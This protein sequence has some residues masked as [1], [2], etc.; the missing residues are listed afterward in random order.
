MFL[1]YA[2]PVSEDEVYSPY[3]YYMRKDGTLIF[4]TGVLREGKQI[5]IL[6]EPVRF[7][8]IVE[9]ETLARRESLFDFPFYSITKVCNE[10]SMENAQDVQKGEVLK[11]IAASEGSIMDF[12]ER[13]YYGGAVFLPSEMAFAFS[14]RQ[15]WRK[16]VEIGN[17]KVKRTSEWVTSVSSITR[18]DLGMTGSGMFGIIDA[19]DEDV[20]MVYFGSLEQLL[21]IRFAIRDGVVNGRFRA[22][23]EFGKVWP[24]RV[25][26]NEDIQQC[27]FF[28]LRDP[29][30][31]FAY[32]AQIDI[33]DQIAEIEFTVSDDRMNMISPIV[34][35]TENVTIGGS[36][37]P[38]L[39]LV[40]TNTFYRGDFYEGDR[41]HGSSAMIAT[42]T[43]FG[44]D[45]FPVYLVK[46]WNVLSKMN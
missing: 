6:A 18:D 27:P 3:S 13:S 29:S 7:P 16:A 8:R 42:L 2:R 25:W 28:V 32:K 5:L 9:I 34:L 12:R 1:E 45:S 41:L 46:E 38:A 17:D 14:P 35:K 22:L 21:Q 33:T 39:P 11:I 20:D 30:E 4:C 43:T 37:A 10:G 19:D 44:G 40:I 36:A 15:A 26:L 23:E 31:S 24:L